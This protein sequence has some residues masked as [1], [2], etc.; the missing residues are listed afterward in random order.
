MDKY[1]LDISIDEE[2]ANREIAASKEEIKRLE[3]KR[4]IEY[5]LSVCLVSLTGSIAI[6]TLEILLFAEQ[7]L[8][9]KIVFAICMCFLIRLLL[10][11][12][13]E[14]QKENFILRKIVIDWRIGEYLFFV[15]SSN[16]WVEIRGFAIVDNKEVVRLKIYGEN[17][18]GIEQNKLFVRSFGYKEDIINPLFDVNNRIFYIP[19]KHKSVLEGEEKLWKRF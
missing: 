3:K 16:Y 6:L 15:N 13:T 10:Y 4:K 18:D 7:S 1:K 12:C 2:R 5:I 11:T 8:T 9:F 17:E 19:E 14:N